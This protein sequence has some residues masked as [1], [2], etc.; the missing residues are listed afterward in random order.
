MNEKS[1]R[2]PIPTSLAS[3]LCIMA[4]G[5]LVA[6]S[7]DGNGLR[8]STAHDAGATGGSGGVMATGGS[9]PS[10]GSGGSGGAPST[11][12]SSSIHTLG[13]NQC[14]GST[15]CDRYS[16][17]VPP[18]GTGPCGVCARVESPCTS[19]SE[20][21]AGGPSF[22]CDVPVGCYCP[23]GAKSC[24]A[25]CT[26]TSDC[27]AGEMCTAHRCVPASCQSDADCPT[28]FT[29]AGGSCA[30]NTCTTDADCSG[31]CVWGTCYSTPGTCYGSVA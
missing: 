3:R 20:C 26:D 29:C 24:M 11:Q 1:I 25:G 15:D 18:G 14:R 2:A 16:T 10:G 5:M 22:I 4:W 17:C 6:C 31:Y 8:N 13:T 27:K 21:Q 12:G 9:D 7:C 19:D 30:R 23:A 28:D